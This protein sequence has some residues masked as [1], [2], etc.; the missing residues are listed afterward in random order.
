MPI[1]Q[2]LF[3]HDSGVISFRKQS[4]T[5][6]LELEDVD[7]LE[8]VSGSD[9]KKCNVIII[10]TNINDFKS[11]L[12]NQGDDFMN[13]KFGEVLTLNI[14]EKSAELLIEWHDFVNNKT[15]V[16][17]Y[18]FKFEKI[19]EKLTSVY[20]QLPEK[21]SDQIQSSDINKFLKSK[22]IKKL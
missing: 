1:M 11:N 8:D 3:F 13:T 18:S 12:E 6:Q 7:L 22:N 20:S 4:K 19:D 21:D 17:L 9:Y 2:N 10:F 15:I 14:K 16:G 5:L